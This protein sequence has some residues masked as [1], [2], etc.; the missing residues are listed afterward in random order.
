M[1]NLSRMMLKQP[2]MLLLTMGHLVTDLYPGFV[3]PILPL[4]Q[5]NL[6]LSLPETAFISSVLSMFSSVF[7][8][9]FGYLSDRFRKT[10]F[11][12][13][14][15]VVAAVFLSGLGFAN[16]YLL[17]LL[18]VSL[19]GIGIAAFHPQG[20]ALA[21]IESKDQPFTGMSM[22]VTG[23]SIG[24][25]IG[26]LIAAPIVEYGSIRSLSYFMII[27]I[28]TGVLHWKII[29]RDA[30]TRHYQESSQVLGQG[31]LLVFWIL[32][33]L[34]LVRAYLFV[35]LHTFIPLY[36]AEAGHTLSYGGVSLFFLHTAA[37]IGG[38]TGGFWA[39]RLG[40]P[41]VI[42][43]SFLL[44]V[45]L[46][47]LYL[48]IGS[49]LGIAFLAL[50]GYILFTSTPLVIALSQKAFPNNISLASSMVMGVTWGVSGLL[51]TP[52][53]V[54]AEQIGLFETLMFLS[55]VPIAGLLL[56]IPISKKL[57]F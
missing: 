24:V 21:G 1:G 57:D 22:F 39:E 18:F 38:F 27:G 12:A 2:K 17:L 4:L 35:A 23:G 19:G 50:A 7:Q 34:A 14:G 55:F 20:A 26:A 46:L 8:L 44:P 49:F 29:S 10:I 33:I 41:K 15:P 37:G 31:S 40:V 25:S 48:L 52:T 56:T 11:V 54:L 13:V 5:K 28:I 51:V 36:L 3:S 16:S 32:I 42:F 43:I 47:I 6:A 53:A 45:P 30:L 9:L